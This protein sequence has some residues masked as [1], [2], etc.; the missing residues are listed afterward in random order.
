MPYYSLT[1]ISFYTANTH[2]CFTFSHALISLDAVNLTLSCLRCLFQVFLWHTVL[3]PIREH[4]T[5]TYN[6]PLAYFSKENE[7][8]SASPPSSFYVI[9]YQG[10]GQSLFIERIRVI[11]RRACIIWF[12]GKEKRQRSEGEK[13]KWSRLAGKSW[14]WAVFSGWAAKPHGDGS[15]NC[16]RSRSKETLWRLGGETVPDSKKVTCLLQ[17]GIPHLGRRLLRKRVSLMTR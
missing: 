14:R 17:W 9:P 8:P 10:P 12:S 7:K 1:A 2:I 13:G 3:I 6:C 11:W 4:F 15:L 5:L 16:K